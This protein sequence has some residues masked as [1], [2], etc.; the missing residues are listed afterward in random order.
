MVEVI[1]PSEVPTSKNPRGEEVRFLVDREP[2]SVVMLTLPPEGR[3]PMHKTPV[4]V[5][6]YV[7][8]GEGEVHIGDESARVRMGDF[9]MSQAELHHVL[10]MNHYHNHVSNKKQAARAVLGNQK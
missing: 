1:R 2:V 3:V 8:A 9:I 10:K 5:L 4:D 6:F 7:S